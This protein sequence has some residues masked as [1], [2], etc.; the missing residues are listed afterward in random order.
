MSTTTADYE[1]KQHVVRAVGN[2]ID[3][4]NRAA[5]VAYHRGQ[6][7]AEQTLKEIRDQL[8]VLQQRLEA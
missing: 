8:R 5:I 3:G 2:V 4:A 1:D 6:T 7:E